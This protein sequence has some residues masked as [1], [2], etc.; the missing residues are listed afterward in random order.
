MSVFSKKSSPIEKRPK[1]PTSYV[2]FK[3]ATKGQKALKSPVEAI[4]KPSGLISSWGFICSQF[5]FNIYKDDERYE[6]CPQIVAQAIEQGWM[7]RVIFDDSER[8]LAT[9]EYDKK[10]RGEW[11]EFDNRYVWRDNG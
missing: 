5:R 2:F 1:V 10:K 6:E 11:A 8:G 4:F 9:L 3:Q 7:L